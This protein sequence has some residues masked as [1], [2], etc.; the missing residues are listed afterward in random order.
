LNFTQPDLVWNALSLSGVGV[1]SSSRGGGENTATINIPTKLPMNNHSN[2]III[3]IRVY[4]K[5]GDT[6]ATGYAG[7]TGDIGYTGYTGSTGDTGYTGYTGST[8]DTGYTG[9][10]G[11]T[12]YTGYTDPTLIPFLPIGITGYTGTTG[13]SYYPSGPTGPTYI[14]TLDQLVQY[15]DTIK[16]SET[17]DRNALD[18]IIT[19]GL[20][21]IQQNLINW[22][23]SGFS[24]DYQ[25]LSVTLIRPS[26]CSDGQTRDMLSY[27]HYLTESDIM[28]LTSNFQ[29]NFLGIYFSYSISDNA[30][31]LHVSKLP[32]A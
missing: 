6:G 7:I 2:D 5:M 11:S 3:L 4:C 27:I 28:S 19:P 17:T 23:S 16:Q 8:G 30:I 15:Y 26:P 25:V 18:V 12:G 24:P 1:V 29:T 32:M 10:T 9:Y 21:N 20:S 14:M 31:N 22:A 13:T